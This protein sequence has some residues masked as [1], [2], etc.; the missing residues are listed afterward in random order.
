M[1]VRQYGFRLCRLLSAQGGCSGSVLGG[2]SFIGS[3]AGKRGRG[4]WRGREDRGMKV[5]VDVGVGDGVLGRFGLSLI[6]VGRGFGRMVLGNVMDE[7][8]L[9]GERCEARAAAEV[10][11]W[12][13]VSEEHV[14]GQ[15]EGKCRGLGGLVRRILRVFIRKIRSQLQRLH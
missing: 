11:Y 7:L 4:L 10:G 1:G 6:G 8:L 9:G 3:G 13:G 2:A 5:G 14:R 12:V 15:E